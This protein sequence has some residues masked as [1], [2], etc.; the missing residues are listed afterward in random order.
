[1]AAAYQRSQRSFHYA[2]CS[3]GRRVSLVR[4]VDGAAFAALALAHGNTRVRGI[5][6]ASRSRRG[7]VR[8][9]AVGHSTRRCSTHIR[10]S[11]ALVPSEPTP[12]Q[13]EVVSDAT[14]EACGLRGCGLMAVAL[15][16]SNDSP[17]PVSPSGAEAG[18]SGAGP[19]GETLKATAPSPQSPVNNSS[20]TR[21]CSSLGSLRRRSAADRPPMGMSSKFGTAPVRRLSA[22]RSRCAAAADP[23]CRPADAARS[24]SISSTR[25]AS[26]RT[27]GNASGPWSANATFRAPAGG[28]VRGNE[29]MDPLTNGRTAGSI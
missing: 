9:F 24:S 21:W 4:I 1:M 22:L 10:R 18:G 11:T 23:R 2:P 6:R 5:S 16:C 8:A 19:A 29:I 14:Q 13:S 26:A 3:S 20:P 17:S 27:F 7:R 25:G 12:S 28:Y 15:G